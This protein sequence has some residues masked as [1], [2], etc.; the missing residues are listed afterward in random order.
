[1]IL[2]IDSN[3]LF[4]ALIK[5]SITADLL[6][7]ENIQLYTPE[8]IISEFFKY[9]DLILDKTSRTE[10]QFIQ[11]MHML[12][13]IITVIPK[14]EYFEFIKEAET[15]SP[16]ERDVMYFALALKFKCEIWSNDKELKEQNKVKIY[17]TKEIMEI[18]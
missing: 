15:I 1:M 9:K 13:E 3:I 8:F 17:N 12:K 11:I 2:V 14:E 6:F 5:N 7:E 18:V 16:D 4:S 10:E